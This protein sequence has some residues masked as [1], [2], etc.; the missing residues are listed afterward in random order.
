MLKQIITVNVIIMNIYR[1]MAGNTTLSENY[2][3]AGMSHVFDQHADSGNYIIQ[4][5]NHKTINDLN[6]IFMKD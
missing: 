3:F 6:P 2:A 1:A 4:S 5:Y